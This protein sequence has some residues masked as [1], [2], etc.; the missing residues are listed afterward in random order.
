[1]SAACEKVKL[2]AV[3]I[4]TLFRSNVIACLDNLI[5]I[6]VDGKERNSLI[7]FRVGFELVPIQ[8]AMDLFSARIIPLSKAIT[9]KSDK[10]FLDPEKSFKLKVG[11][12]ELDWKTIWESHYLN[13]EDKAVIWKYMQLFLGLAEGYKS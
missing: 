12:I 3:E 5:E 9:S 13:K 1:M 4:L 10:F 2:S 11:D 8:D 6:F 7:A